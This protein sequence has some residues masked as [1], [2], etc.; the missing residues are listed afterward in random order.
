LSTALAVVDSVATSWK[1]PTTFAP[2]IEADTPPQFSFSRTLRTL[3]VGSSNSSRIS[4]REP[5]LMVV[6]VPS[7]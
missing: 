7:K 6:I 1:D 3:V 5:G 4:S 2:G